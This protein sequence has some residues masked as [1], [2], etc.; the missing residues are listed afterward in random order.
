MVESREEKSRPRLGVNGYLDTVV[1][2]D[3]GGTRRARISLDTRDPASAEAQRREWLAGVHPKHPSNGHAAAAKR[4]PASTGQ[5]KRQGVTMARLLDMCWSDP[6]CWAKSKSQATI[7]SNVKLLTARIGDLLPSEL[8]HQRLCKLADEM[9]AEGYAPASVKRKL[10]MVSKALRM[11]CNAYVDADG[12]P[13][14]LQKPTMPELKLDNV[15]SRVLTHEEETLVF[16]AMD[17][18]MIDEPGR[19]WLRFR[20]FVRLALDTAFRRGEL[21]LLGPASVEML[22]VNGED[23]VFIG[24]PRYATKNDK[25]RLVPATQAV[26]DLIPTLNAQAVPDKT[27]GQLRWFP[28]DASAW[29]MWDNV[30][31]DVK[32]LGG[33]IDDVGLHTLRHTCI[34][35]LAKGGMEL[36]RL[37]MFAGHSSVMI[38]ASRYSHLQAQDL[39]DAAR[40]LSNPAKTAMGN[41]LSP[42][43]NRAEAGTPTVQ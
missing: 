12:K 17:K 13:L 43:G 2:K 30:R 8:T 38:T 23:A 5:T 36:Q 22:T 28:L 20:A 1:P 31:H 40:I 6:R 41:F 27:T 37:S 24:L 42:G 39:A 19:Q 18:R 34:T 15:K 7:R 26:V 10:D 25:P 21:L 16:A 9:I 4:R 3:G 29:Y 14:L 11:A 35:R 32:L 33:D